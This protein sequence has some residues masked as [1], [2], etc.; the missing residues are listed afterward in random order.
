MEKWE[1]YL[2]VRIHKKEKE[3]LENSLSRENSI[4]CPQN[5]EVGNKVL[6]ESH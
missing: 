4:N 3:K 2:W 6:E 5:E 1:K